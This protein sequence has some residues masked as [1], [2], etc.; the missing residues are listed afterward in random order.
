MMK[1]NYYESILK[2]IEITLKKIPD[3]KIIALIEFLS[4]PEKI[5]IAGA[6]RSGLIMKT[7]AIRLM[8]MGF[9]VHI[10]GEATTPAIRPGD[11]LFIGSG[12]GETE[13]LVL[14]AKKA[15][16][17]GAKIGL[18]TMSG[19]SALGTIADISVVIPAKLSK[20]DFDAQSD[21]I[22]PMCN[23]FEQALLIFL[24]SLSISMLEYKDIDKKILYEKHANLE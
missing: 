2:E 9:S 22:Q 8:Q 6:G 24:D 21:S 18:I 15:K 3:E 16:K 17:A 11:I 1:Y 4:S 12:S 10:Q 19:E 14:F 5:F 23:L 13:S 20:K 7:F